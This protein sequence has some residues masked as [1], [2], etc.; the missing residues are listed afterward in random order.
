MPIRDLRVY[1]D[2]MSTRHFSTVVFTYFTSAYNIFEHADITNKQG[3]T[4]QGDIL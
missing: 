4:I 1:A 2:R 3:R